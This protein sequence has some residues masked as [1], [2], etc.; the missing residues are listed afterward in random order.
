MSK[1]IQGILPKDLID[2]VLW[3][4]G[5]KWLSNSEETW[6]TGSKEYDTNMEERQISSF[7]STMAETTLNKIKKCRY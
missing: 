1:R 2:H 3:W 5:P 6:K 7:H 4:T